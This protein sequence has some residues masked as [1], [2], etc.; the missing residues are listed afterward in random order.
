MIKRFILSCL[1]IISL[2]LW[3]WFNPIEK[4]SVPQKSRF[5]KL[6][7]EGNIMNSW[8]GLW[9]CIVD[10]KTG[11]TWEVKSLDESL[12]DKE[13]S[14]SWFNGQLG[15]RNGEQCF[16]NQGTSDTLNIIKM[17]NIEQRCGLKNWRLPT[18]KELRSLLN[19]TQ[20]AGDP[21]IAMD[22]FP[23]SKPEPYWTAT[24]N[25]ELKGFFSYLKTGAIAVNFQD[26]K[27]YTLP[28]QNSAYVRLVTFSR[29]THPHS[30]YA[31]PSLKQ[32]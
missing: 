17:T 18:E 8:A 31:I 6:S 3:A 10:S 28:Y 25:E 24:H 5:I 32:M 21:L 26:A 12:H 13:C 20:K 11:L 14:F 4:P 7:M 19:Q 30:P 1:I 29:T 2:V 15:V 22:Y 9:H 16:A 23:Y 27:S